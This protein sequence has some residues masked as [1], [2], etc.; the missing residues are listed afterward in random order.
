MEEF[1]ETI[2]RKLKSPEF[3]EVPA[4]AAAVAVAA[5]AVRAEPI[6]SALTAAAAPTFKV[7]VFVF[8]LVSLYICR[9]T[10]TIVRILLYM[11]QAERK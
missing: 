1:H 2:Q 11:L 6:G 9:H 4:A 7:G 10:T 5:A 8:F 3:S